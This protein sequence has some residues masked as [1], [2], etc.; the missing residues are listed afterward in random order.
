MQ[1][2]WGTETYYRIAKMGSLEKGHPAMVFLRQLVDKA[3]KVLDLGCGEGT[4]LSSLSPKSGWGIDI[5]PKAI[6]LAKKK[7]PRLHLLVGDLENLPLK[8]QKFDLIYSAFVFEHLDDPVKAIKEALRVLLPGG[9]LVIIAPNYGAPNR[10][11]P[12]FKGNRFRKLI[13]GFVKDFFS[14][15]G[16]SWQK[17]RPLSCESYYEIDR[18]TT[19]E[20]YLGSLIRYLKSQGERILYTS[21]CWSEELPS[22]NPL[23]R[24]IRFLGERKI[25][26][27]SMWGP[28]LVVVAQK[29]VEK[30]NA[31]NNSP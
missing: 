5:S 30:K 29:G 25:F 24:I 9:K 4:R 2:V 20:P 13:T 31:C 22:A 16:L 7:Y 19:I 23:Q 28:H 1:K 27:F 8:K 11:S 15:P 12:P 10:A 6:A 18:D 14:S 17:V 3:S 21:S 26:P